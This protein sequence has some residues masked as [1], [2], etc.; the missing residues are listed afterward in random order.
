VAEFY[1]NTTPPVH[2]GR[3]DGP[4]DLT[5]GMEL[6][7]SAVAKAREELAGEIARDLH[8]RRDVVSSI[9]D[10]VHTLKGSTLLPEREDIGALLKAYSSEKI[11]RSV[12]RS[13]TRKQRLALAFGPD[14]KVERYMEARL[15]NLI[16][17]KLTISANQLAREAEY[18]FQIPKE[19]A[20]PVAK[21][22][23]HRIATRERR[24][25]APE[26]VN[27][28]HRHY[29]LMPHDFHMLSISGVIASNTSGE[30][31]RVLGAALSFLYQKGRLKVLA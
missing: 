31:L 29:S 19:V 30:A 11:L 3:A 24:F 27:R 17:R 1:R 25:R 18:Y 6:P 28:L 2:A 16:R 8:L 20:K 5:V 23:R 13:R 15:V 7:L 21:R 22:V 26:N 9:Y 12:L 10:V 14:D 4:A